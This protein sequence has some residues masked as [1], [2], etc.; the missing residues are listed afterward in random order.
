MRPLPYLLLALLA[1]TSCGGGKRLVIGVSQCSADVWREKQNA[2]LRTCAWFHDGVE[3]RFVS[4]GDNDKRQVEQIDSLV[5]SGIDALIVAPNQMSTINPAIDRAFDSGIP[6][7]VFERKTSSRKYTA[8][9]SADNY[10]IGRQM[11]EW[12]AARLGGKGKVLVVAGLRG[13][14][15]AIEREK[16]FRDEIARHSGIETIATLQG[17]W[18]EPTAYKA[19][20]KWLGTHN[21]HIDLV[22]GLNDRSAMGAR[23]ALE[24]AHRPMPCLIGVDGLPGKGG[25]IELVRQGKLDATYIYPT[26][27]DALLELAL[28][29]FEGRKYDKEIRLQAAIVTP[30][31][32]GV[33]LMQAQE[34][35]RQQD[36]L[37]R[38][39]TSARE[40]LHELRG[41][42]LLTWIAVGGAL[43]L[44]AALVM[45][46]FYF[47]QRARLRDER[48]RLAREQLDFYTQASHRLRT[49]IT[50]I[51]GPLAQIATA[52]NQEMLEVVKRNAGQL[53]ELVEE[54]LAGSI[55]DQPDPARLASDLSD[56]AE[57]S[58]PVEKTSAAI[59]IADDNADVRAYVRTILAN[60]T[61]VEARD[62]REGL[63][64]ARREVPDIIVSDVMMP[65]MNGLEF[66]QAV[67]ED[68]IT[69]HIPVVLLTARA[70]SRHQVEGY[71]VG[72][73]AYITKPFDAEVLRAC[74]AAQLRGRKKLRELWRKDKSDLSDKSDAALIASDLPDKSDLSPEPASAPDPRSALFAA[75]FRAVVE[76]RMAK[77]DLSVEDI[78]AEMNLSRV[79]LYRKVKAITGSTPVEH[80]R[81]ARLAK[82]REMLTTTEMSVSEAA[83]A[84]GFTAPSY[85]TKYYKEEFG[86]LPS[87]KR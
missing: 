7:V 17:D 42:K 73:D 62:G 3:L 78:A 12:A 80:L 33:L 84:C 50:L 25:G 14:S 40:Y 39:H 22:F 26:E 57:K 72:A 76:A 41:Q 69:S 83:Y 74:V 85:F 15:P 44:L 27:G 68:D 87:G 37:D 4:A 10:A 36:Y 48:E 67:K 19:M 86:T 29:I 35:T 52:D 60:Y 5:D 16:G 8:F 51:T 18:T 11:G 1:L 77:S 30:D 28:D 53:A 13:S 82:A 66:C 63:E 64:T 34:M 65:V 71:R 24:E 32:A 20:R 31:N 9:V 55:S 81:R 46:Y 23:R 43:L 58:E 70:L 47:L 75:R 54:I 21:E 56:K 49:P 79:Q 61:I 6:V 2:E 45:L 59:L 38:L